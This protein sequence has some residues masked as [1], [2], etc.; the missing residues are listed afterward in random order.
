MWI[1]ANNSDAD[2]SHPETH[3]NYAS[4]WRKAFVDTL[5]YAYGPLLVSLAFSYL[6]A[7]QDAVTELVIVQASDWATSSYF[8][9]FFTAYSETADKGVGFER[10]IHAAFSSIKG[11]ITGIAAI[12]SLIF[13]TAMLFY[14]ARIAL[15]SRYLR[16]LKTEERDATSDDRTKQRGFGFEPPSKEERRFDDFLLVVT[17]MAPAFAVF[18]VALK[19][20][21]SAETATPV[22]YI[23][24]ITTR[25]G[26][27][28][29]LITGIFTI[30]LLIILLAWLLWTSIKMR[31]NGKLKLT[32]TIPGTPFN[33]KIMIFIILALVTLAIW[34]PPTY[35]FL[36]PLAPAALFVGLI[37]LAFATMT[38]HSVTFSF[39]R[40]PLLLLPVL[41]AFAVDMENS[42]WV[43]AA[44]WAVAVVLIWITR[45][46]SRKSQRWAA[47]A[48]CVVPLF[49]II[50]QRDL[51]RCSSL[52]GCNII[53]GVLKSDNQNTQHD[54][55]DK[56][57]AA[58]D[59]S[60]MADP[61][62]AE[63]P[64]R[65]IA[66]QG[67]GLYTAYHTA[68]YLAHKADT[69]PVFADSIFAISGVS[70]G[71][72]GA[73]AYW[74]VRASEQC[75][76]ALPPTTCHRDGVNEVLARDYLSPVVATMLFRDVPDGVIPYTAAINQR[77]DRGYLLEN[78]LSD[79]ARLWRSENGLEDRNAPLQSRDLNTIAMVDS[80]PGTLGLP[81]LLLNA[82]DVHTGERRIAAP[83]SFADDR[84]AEMVIK[85]D[86]PT[87]D[88]SV[89]TGAV[90]SARFPVVTPPAR[91]PIN[92]QN[93]FI[94]DGGY[95]DNS[96]LETVAD[97]LSALEKPL[98]RIPIEVITFKV[99]DISCSPFQDDPNTAQDESSDPLPGKCADLMRNGD[100]GER[101]DLRPPTGAMRTPMVA[102]VSAWN[103]RRDLSATRL[104]TFLSLLRP[105]AVSTVTP[106]E[107]RTRDINFTLSWLL[108]QST[109]KDICR[110]IEGGDGCST[111]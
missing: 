31:H 73:A 90:L 61:A 58:W 85:L 26:A 72:V 22:D 20:Y 29:A 106:S 30:G 101:M 38:R 40:L 56:A 86:D 52:A 37:A 93:H 107:I 32:S 10:S 69:D 99:T 18:W 64:V 87:R 43:L 70:G 49:F 8:L 42:G 12:I 59:A 68:Y 54:D 103:A 82:T 111:L 35:Q 104:E 110:Q 81:A 4:D 102:F 16:P 80:F 48:M 60:R 24:I 57:F 2:A 21:F 13:M 34:N 98:A 25:V 11:L 74:A 79:K 97:L 84:G 53:T 7:M 39:L 89:A 27:A 9:D 109:F 100:D 23:P 5:E 15:N 55:I 19:A 50:H 1:Q 28:D 44:I 92:G 95:F 108:A 41:L 83:F 96:G 91:L 88:I 36:G 65:I 6:V 77:T 78:L 71:S 66:A 51:A 62:V 105:K 45:D 17:V 75:A 14:A 94:V 76:D 33:L 67:G 47:M 63:E 46:K 3:F